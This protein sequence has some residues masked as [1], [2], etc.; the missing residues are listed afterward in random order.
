MTPAIKFTVLGDG[1][2]DRVL[3]SSIKWLLEQRVR[4]RPIEAAWADLGRLRQPPTNLAERVVEAI[5]LY[6]CDLLFIHRDAENQPAQQRYDEI[7]AVVSDLELPPMICV[8]PVRMTEAWQLF[9][10]AALR[11]AAGNPNGGVVLSMPCVAELELVLDP[12]EI[13]YNLLRQASEL[14]QGRLKKFRV[15]VRAARL[16]DYLDDFSP[17]RL[18]TAFNRLEADID[19]VVHVKGWDLS[20]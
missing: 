16:V 14:P 13:L 10:E 12:K 8:V 4:S 15:H 7:H 5:R 6:P 19:E 11:R 18:L 9:N 20:P 3:R 1:G 17:L 2:T